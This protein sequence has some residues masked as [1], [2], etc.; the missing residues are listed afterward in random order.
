MEG[1]VL[2]MFYTYN[3]GRIWA[4]L[5]MQYVQSVPYDGSAPGPVVTIQPREFFE[6]PYRASGS[7]IKMGK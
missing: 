4:K 3:M 2:P 7:T 1:V 6:E 5:C